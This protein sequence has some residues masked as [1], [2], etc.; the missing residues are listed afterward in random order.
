MLLK[1]DRTQWELCNL[2]FFRHSF[3][4]DH[5]GRSV[6][7]FKPYDR[8]EY[9]LSLTIIRIGSEADLE[10]RIYLGLDGW[11]CEVLEL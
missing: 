6:C 8:N 1:G 2:V 11:F 3:N 5:F 4:V 10:F 9:L 7:I